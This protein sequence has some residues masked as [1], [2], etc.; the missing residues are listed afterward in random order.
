MK[1]ALV[2]NPSGKAVQLNAVNA[3]NAVIGKDPV[4]GG[5]LVKL[6]KAI[7]KNN[8]SLFEIADAMNEINKNKDASLYGYKTTAEMVES[9]Y[10]YKKSST[11]KMISVAEYFL[12]KDNQGEIHSVFAR[13]FD[14]ERDVPM[15]CL[16][17]LL[18]DKET[19][20]YRRAEVIGFYTN[21]EIES[22]KQ[23]ELRKL[24]QGLQTIIK[25]GLP[26]TEESYLAIDDKESDKESDK[27]EKSKEKEKVSS[28]ETANDEG[29]SM[30]AL[31]TFESYAGA[32]GLL[33]LNETD[34]EIKNKMIEMLHDT[35]K[36]ITEPEEVL[37]N[38]TE[39]T[40]DKKKAAKN[41]K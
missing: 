15:T 38:E 32:L 28:N 10:G 29:N 9:M 25:K 27:K 8:A 39:D 34:P 3:M 18:L 40:G 26:L 5:R 19:M 22:M 6:N 37:S 20:K 41:K 23:G 13:K 7:N 14:G 24:K 33:Y 35:I 30:N 2:V 4:A 36:V 17:E 21:F 11:S 31:E 12:E 1:N 16:Y